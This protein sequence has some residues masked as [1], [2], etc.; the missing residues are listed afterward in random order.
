MT[1]D[2]HI[3][4]LRLISS[5]RS[6]NALYFHPVKTEKYVATRSRLAVD[7]G[8][9]YQ[10]LKMKNAGHVG[11]VQEEQNFV[12]GDVF[13]E[14]ACLLHVQDLRIVRMVAAHVHNLQWKQRR[15]NARAA[16]ILEIS[17]ASARA[18]LNNNLLLKMQ[19]HVWTCPVHSAGSVPEQY[20][21]ILGF[22]HEIKSVVHWK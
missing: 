2:V 9:A 12:M 11:D 1:I 21:K 10:I 19:L 22:V 14:D 13:L 7:T 5:P 8:N 20:L 17:N 15:E 4:L 3:G 18:A 16:A 6:S